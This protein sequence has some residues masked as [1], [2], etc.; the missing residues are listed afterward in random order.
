M[1]NCHA[2]CARL[3]QALTVGWSVSVR[4]NLEQLASIALPKI[5]AQRVIYEEQKLSVRWPKSPLAQS[6]WEGH[7]SV[8]AHDNARWIAW[9]RVKSEKSECAR[10]CCP[11]ARLAERIPRSGFCERLLIARA[12]ATDAAS[13][14]SSIYS[15]VHASRA[16]KRAAARSSFSCDYKI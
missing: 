11:K 15:R 3:M 9:K 13:L 14:K 2:K 6:S 10:A 12:R 16:S 5:I 7:K 4:K 8:G 1:I